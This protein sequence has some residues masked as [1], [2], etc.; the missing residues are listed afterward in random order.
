MRSR[1]LSIHELYSLNS[2]KGVIQGILSGTTIRDIKGDTRSLDN[3]TH[4][5]WINVRDPLHSYMWFI[6]EFYINRGVPSKGLGFKAQGSRFRVQGLGSR[7]RVSLQRGYICHIRG[8]LYMVYRG[9]IH[10]WG[11][12]FKG[13]TGS[14]F[15]IWGPH[16]KDLLL[17]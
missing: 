6:E 3:G 5:N 16:E 4:K 11:C 9:V 12:P 8:E 17:L 13:V 2:L 7:V 14:L 10:K 1:L 15:C